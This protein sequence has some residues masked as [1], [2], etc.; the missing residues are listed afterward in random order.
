VSGARAEGRL[1]TASEA[2]D[3]NSLKAAMFDAATFDTLQFLN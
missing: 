1:P 3:E 2:F